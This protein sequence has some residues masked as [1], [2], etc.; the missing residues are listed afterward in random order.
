MTSSSSQSRNTSALKQRAL[1]EALFLKEKRKNYPWPAL[2]KT[3]FL[4]EVVPKS[5]T[6]RDSTAVY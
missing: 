6:S 4:Q 5:T 1:E 2:L 3:S